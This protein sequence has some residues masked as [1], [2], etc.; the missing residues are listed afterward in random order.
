M[1]EYVS[2][3]N[4]IVLHYEKPQLV[5]HSA[6]SERTGKFLRLSGIA[7]AQVDVVR[8]FPIV[9]LEEL[10]ERCKSEKGR[11][12]YVVEFAD[13][14][15]VKMKTLWYL[16]QHCGWQQRA[17][18]RDLVQGGTLKKGALLKTILDNA[19]DDIK[20]HFISNSTLCEEI[21]QVE[22]AVLNYLTTSVEKL[23][24][25]INMCA[26]NPALLAERCKAHGYITFV[27]RVLPRYLQAHATDEELFQCV[28][29]D[30][31]RAD[32]GT[33]MIVQML[34]PGCLLRT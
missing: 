16:H 7:H 25:V 13:G 18:L 5:L 31:R 20:A 32:A 11:E 4:Q 24:A 9:T 17:T 10:R 33:G 14:Q 21:D 26:D 30:M 3:S 8:T 29:A 19:L 12:G 23:Q 27:Q 15:L 6:R 34:A 22:A 2:P 1:G 28:A